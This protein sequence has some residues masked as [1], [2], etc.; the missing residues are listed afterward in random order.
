MVYIEPEYIYIY[1]NLALIYTMSD[2]APEQHFAPDHMAYMHTSDWI[3]T[4][5]TYTHKNLKNA[6]L[7]TM[8]LPMMANVKCFVY[9]G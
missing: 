5:R 6:R 1:I 7:A 4:F 3:C 9:V 8:L 2:R